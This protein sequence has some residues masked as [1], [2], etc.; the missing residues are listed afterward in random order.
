M[1]VNNKCKTK[2]QCVGEMAYCLA[3]QIA[4]CKLLNTPLLNPRFAS[5]KLY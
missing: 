3:L 1:H 4:D 2:G 5:A